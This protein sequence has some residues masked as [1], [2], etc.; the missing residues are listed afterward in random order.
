[1]KKKLSPYDQLMACWKVRIDVGLC[2]S[3][4]GFVSR[5]YW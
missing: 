2:R 5:P 1:M 4:N 3:V